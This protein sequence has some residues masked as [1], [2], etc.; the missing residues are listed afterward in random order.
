MELTSKPNSTA[1]TLRQYINRKG[2]ILDGFD[3]ATPSSTSVRL[4][5]HLAGFWLNAGSFSP[6]N[7]ATMNL[8]DWS[9]KIFPALAY[10][11]CPDRSV[12]GALWSQAYSI[13]L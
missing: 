2:N 5:V 12:G 13:P 7:A 8:A 1:G 9:W 11:K 3:K 10:V 4:T 6:L